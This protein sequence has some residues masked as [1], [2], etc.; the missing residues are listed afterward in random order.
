[1]RIKIFFLFF[2]FSNKIF[3]IAT[4]WNMY[5]AKE[6]IA[7]TL[8]AFQVSTQESGVIF[9]TSRGPSGLS[10]ESVIEIRYKSVSKFFFKKTP[11]SMTTTIWWA[12]NTTK[13]KKQLTNNIDIDG[14][15]VVA[16][17]IGQMYTVFAWIGLFCCLVEQL[18]F[19]RG[20]L[21]THTST[22]W[23]RSSTLLK[24]KLW[25]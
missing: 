25:R 24:K 22:L 8:G 11:N 1:M 17:F 7:L 5:I 13:K 12:Q 2:F 21:K 23:Q 3:P 20:V 4:L 16:L 15:S 10:G 18:D 9:P 19:C 6:S 14:S